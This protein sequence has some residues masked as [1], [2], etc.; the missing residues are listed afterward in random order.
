MLRVNYNLVLIALLVVIGCATFQDSYADLYRGDTFTDLDYGNQTHIWTGGLSPYVETG[1]FDQQG[2]P[3]Y[4]HH[5]IED[6]PTYV[7]VTNGRASFVFDKTTCSAKVYKGGVI[8][9]STEFIIASDSFTPKFSID[10]SG[11]WSIVNSV[12]D[13]PCVTEII[14][15]ANSI[16]VSGTKTSSAGV[17]KVRYV[18]ED[19]K[20][21]ESFLEATNLTALTDRRF[22]IT[23]TMQIPHIVKWGDQLIDLESFVGQTKDR[24]WLENNQANLLELSQGLKFDTLKAWD[25]LESVSVNSVSNGLASISFNYIRNTPILLPNETLVIDPTYSQTDTYFISYIDKTGSNCDGAGTIDPYASGMISGYYLTNNWCYRAGV[26]F[27]TTSIPDYSDVTDID[28]KFE[29]VTGGETNGNC[30]YKAITNQPN[31]GASNSAKF[32][33]FGDGTTYLSNDTTCKGAGTGKSVD[34]GTSADSDLETSLQAGTNWWGFGFR[35]NN[36]QTAATIRSY[37]T[38]PGT[39]DYTLEVAYN[40]RCEAPTFTF[41]TTQSTTSMKLDWTRPASACNPSGYKIYESKN[42][43]SYTFKVE[44]GNVTTTTFSTLDTGTKYSYKLNTVNVN[45]DGITNS[46]VRTNATLPVSPVSLVATPVSNTKINV[47]YS[48]GTQ[49][50]VLWFKSRHAPLLGGPWTN[51]NTNSSVNT[52]RYENFT[53]LTTGIQYNLQ[54]ASGTIGGFGDWSAN[55][56][57]RPITTTSGT[58]SYITENVGDMFTFNGTVSSVIVSPSPQTVTQIKIIDNG[59]IVDTRSISDTLTDTVNATLTQTSLL[60]SDDL[61]HQIKLRITASNHTG[62]VTID[63][64][65]QNLTREYEPDY[66]TA[67]DP[68]QGQVNY[69]F[70][71]NNIIKVNRSFNGSVFNIEC[72]YFTHADAF[73]D[74]FD[75]GVWDNRSNVYYYKGDVS[76]YYYIQCFN[77]GELFITAISQNYSNSLVPGLL[78]FDELGGFFGAPSIILV[79]LAILSLGTGRNY[80]IILLIAASVTGILLALE[81]LVLDPGLVVALVVMAGIG[82]FGIRKF[83]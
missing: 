19:G 56:T 15:T 18:K 25:N 63:S 37:L 82:I 6:Q 27:T 3:I 52:P 62:T 67:I 71:D 75:L 22:G 43:A 50:N 11:T 66:F 72:Q 60:F 42:S 17:F 30:D 12:N 47:D 64:P 76:N 44:T 48:D 13:A 33:D 28:F 83:Y 70:A 39:P 2:R 36:E 68:T 31:G 8:E 53:G 77:D 79:I 61:L 5:I 14:E 40:L 1:N 10:G 32:I 58:L 78:I 20:P 51:F 41:L 65:I 55:L 54:I 49:P 59:T 34:L 57:A 38:N 9:N 16:E 35:Q 7:K 4:A 29:S 69:T 23:Q 24:S 46:T 21:L 45:G 80:P 26:E 73:F 74:N 81:L